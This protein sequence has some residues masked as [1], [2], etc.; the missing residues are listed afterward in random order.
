M[1]AYDDAVLADSPVFYWPM[2]ETSGTTIADA[3]GNSRTGTISGDYTLN[4]LGPSSAIPASVDFGYSSAKIVG[5]VGTVFAPSSLTV[6]CWVKFDTVNAEHTLHFKNG[7]DY[8]LRLQSDG[9]LNFRRYNNAAG[10]QDV[11]YGTPLSAGVWYHVVVASDGSGQFMYVNG[12]QV[13][14]SAALS[15]TPNATADTINF[16]H[17]ASAQLMDGKAAAVAIY[18][19][20]LNSTRVAAHYAAAFAGRTH[21]MIL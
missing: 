12:A 14:S 20:A 19:T 4:Q 16:G 8:F 9:T 15:G 13:A 11:T 2:N 7:P 1:T 10:S 5:L 18:A 21:Q 3:S 6:E 17:N